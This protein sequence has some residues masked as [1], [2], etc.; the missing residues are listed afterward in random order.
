MVVALSLLCGQFRI[1]D[2]FT[3]R[4]SQPCIYLVQSIHFAIAFVQSEGE[5]LSVSL[6]VLYNERVVNAIETLLEHRPTRSP[7]RWC[8][9]CH[10]ARRACP[11]RGWRPPR[12][13]R[14]RSR[15]PYSLRIAPRN[16]P[17]RS[18]GLSPLSCPRS[19][20]SVEL[21]GRVLIRLLAADGGFIGGHEASQE[22]VIS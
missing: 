10:G 13:Q 12:P 8:G 9:P 14:G 5:L 2:S 21:F 4:L 1:R 15:S 3:D 16:F 7:G 18:W 20:V 19:R 11:Y 6:Q 17:P 22:V